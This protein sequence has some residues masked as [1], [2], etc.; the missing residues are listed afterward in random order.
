ML[1]FTSTL[2]CFLKNG[3][4]EKVKQKKNQ[5]GVITMIS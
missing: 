5:N 1:L 3:Q 4:K 2:Q